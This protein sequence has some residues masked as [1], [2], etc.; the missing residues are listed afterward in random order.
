MDLKNIALNFFRLL[1]DFITRKLNKL[2]TL[3]NIRVFRI[4]ASFIGKSIIKISLRV[5]NLLLILRTHHLNRGESR[6]VRRSIYITTSGRIR[7]IG[8]TSRTSDTS[9]AGRVIKNR[10]RGNTSETPTSRGI[11]RIIVTVFT[12]P[13]F[14]LI[15][16]LLLHILKVVLLLKGHFLLLVLPI[17]A[18]LNTTEEGICSTGSD[19]TNS[20][21]GGR[22]HQLAKITETFTKI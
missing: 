13:C 14:L 22:P 4:T 10:V 17:A 3:C 16:E 21:S 5:S 11:T 7:N 18:S 20:T 15:F 9:T 1:G 8:S 19:I 12:I 6:M 2:R